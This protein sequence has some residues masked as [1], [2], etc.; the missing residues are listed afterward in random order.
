MK[1]Y[2]LDCAWTLPSRQS[3]LAELALELTGL[4]EWI[5]LLDQNS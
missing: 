2:Q 4:T 5:L 1:K 3:A